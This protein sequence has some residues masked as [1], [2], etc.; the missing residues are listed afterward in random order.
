M[1]DS[2]VRDSPLLV[3]GQ[4]NSRES[5]RF[6]LSIRAIFIIFE[7]IYANVHNVEPINFFM[8]RRIKKN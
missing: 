1:R 6:S 5:G 4:N 7:T 2:T 3:R 8:F